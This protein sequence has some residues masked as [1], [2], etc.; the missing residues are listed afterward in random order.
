MVKNASGKGHHQSFTS[1]WDVG[2]LHVAGGEQLHVS[3]VEGGI[4]RK[5]VLTGT[6]WHD[7]QHDLEL[8]PGKGAS[9]FSSV[10]CLY[11]S[12]RIGN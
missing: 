12:L 4:G 8:G 11:S 9:L 6:A 1:A 10:S 7:V 2:P 3:W 5:P